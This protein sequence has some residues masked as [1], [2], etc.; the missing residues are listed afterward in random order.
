MQ[1]LV[2]GMHRAGTSAFTRLINQLGAYVGAE[3]EMTDTGIGQENPKGHWERK[4][5]REANEALM[6]S[7]GCDWDDVLNWSRIEPSA[8]SLERFRRHTNLIALR[9][10]ANRPWAIKD[11]RLCL[12][13]SHWLP[14]LELPVPFVVLRD[15]GEV[16]VSLRTRN[17]FPLELGFALWEAHYRAMLRGI[18]GRR[19]VLADHRDLLSDPVATAKR[20]LEEFIQAGVRKLSSP[21]DLELKMSIDP[22][23]YRSKRE[24]LAGDSSE[25]PAY[26]LYAAMASSKGSF[27]GLSGELSARSI[28]ALERHQ[29]QLEQLRKRFT[30]GATAPQA[31]TSSQVQKGAPPPATDVRS[32]HGPLALPVGVELELQRLSSLAT[33]LEIEL[34]TAGLHQAQIGNE[35]SDCR[36]QL[37]AAREKA[38]DSA[39]QAAAMASE[40]SAERDARKRMDEAWQE[41]RIEMARLSKAREEEL[42]AESSRLRVRLDELENEHRSLALSH[43]SRLD[44]LAH[45]RETLTISYRKSLSDAE[46]VAQVLRQERDELSRQRAS[47][48]DAI[49]RVRGYATTIGRTMRRAEVAARDIQASVRWRVGDRF[50]RLLELV[51]LRDRPILSWSVLQDA[52]ADCQ[53]ALSHLESVAHATRRGQDSDQ[54]QRTGLPT[55]GQLTPKA[56]EDPS[57]VRRS[58]AG[59]R[60][61]RPHGETDLE[62]GGSSLHRLQLVERIRSALLAYKRSLKIRALDSCLRPFEKLTGL[63]PDALNNALHLVSQLERSCR[64][65]EGAIATRHPPAAP[66]VQTNLDTQQ[67]TVGGGTASPEVGRLGSDGAEAAPERPRRRGVIYTAVAGAYDGLKQPEFIWEDCDYVVFTD[68]EIVDPGVWRVHRMDYVN[69]DPTRSARFVKTH[70]HLYFADYAFSLWIDANLLLR[71]NGETLRAA[72]GSAEMGAFVHPHRDCVYS[73]AEEVIRRGG[74]DDKSIVQQHVASLRA[75]DYPVRNGL[76]ETNVLFRRHNA[77]TVMRL[78]NEWWRLIEN[79]SKRDQL[80]FNV[81]CWLTDFEVQ[82]LAA[83]GISV[84]NH[85]D[86]VRFQHGAASSH[87]PSQP[88]DAVIARMEEARVLQPHAIS[89]RIDQLSTRTATDVIVCVHNARDDVHACLS[90][91][92]PTLAEQDRLIVVDDGSD[93][94][95]QRMLEAFASERP[96]MHVVRRNTAGGYTV[97]ANA[98]YR[99]SRN[100]FLVFLNSDTIVPPNWLDKLRELAFS[101]PEIGIVGPLSNAASWQSV[102]RTLDESGKLAVNSLP[103]GLSVAEADAWCLESTVGRVFVPLINGFCFGVKRSVFDAIG[104]FDEVSFPRGYGEENDFCFRAADA[105]FLLAVATNCFVFHAKSKSYSSAGRDELAQAGSR[106]FRAKYPKARIDN[107][108]ATTRDNPLL[109]EVRARFERRQAA[110]LAGSECD[111]ADIGRTISP[112]P[113]PEEAGGISAYDLT[114]DDMRLNSRIVNSPW[115]FADA[116]PGSVL[117]FVPCF[118]HALRG[119]IRTI[120]TAAEDWSKSWGTFHYFALYGNSV[121]VRKC[122]AQLRQ[123]FPNLRYK[124]IPIADSVAVKNLP[125][126]DLGICTLWN[127]AYHL[128]KYNRCRA[129]M[130]FAQ[131]YEPTFY[132]AGTTYG[133]IQETYG[134]GFNVI[135]NSA[136]VGDR[137]REHTQRVDSFDPGVDTD[138]FR[139][140]PLKLLADQPRRIVFYGRPRNPRNAFEL[141]MESLR[142]LK[143]RMGEKV[144]IISVGAEFDPA[145]YGC[146]GA[147]RNLGVLASMEE[148]ADLYAGARAGLVF[149]YSAHPSYQPLEYMASGCATVTNAN[150]SN[151]WLLRN[152]ENCLVTRAVPSEIAERLAQVVTDDKLYSRIRD[153]GLRTV[154]TLSWPR[155]LER[156][157]QIVRRPT[158]SDA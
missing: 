155:A 50:V 31:Q 94:A 121:N 147:V 8:R 32:G 14:L 132:R 131:D 39:E 104:E 83:R 21:A 56:L 84:R 63:R 51:L 35:L 24:P 153:G 71:G 87:V 93:D 3:G 52:I 4:D 120:F 13:I 26:E 115:P 102:P 72:L 43:Q 44:E 49:S 34:A 136:G 74:L 126:T 12:T 65:E 105:G 118:D 60:E 133:L 79:G 127:S 80:S 76:F 30:K 98:G 23:L 53:N 143:Q 2:V 16:A 27:A 158:R 47:D 135:A 149:M 19:H 18:A 36:K 152:G 64:G 81:A 116:P 68:Q 90:S 82:P 146:E 100:P 137:V 37:I 138:L 20:I 107:A 157:R 89:L 114:A 154:S 97:A 142:L 124:V 41:D 17:A 29:K 61:S 40:L 140:A 130:Y 109:A 7:V 25:H 75:L 58:G 59:V 67:R 54:H 69:A 122:N 150:Y 70:P 73:E 117:W 66:M 111:V 151:R 108:I 113:L 101:S 103:E 96:G 85:P 119:G 55:P 123:Y 134:F 10:D 145:E 77:A 9:L 110:W 95:T 5:V 22:R 11:P 57:V 42:E 144:D 91:V 156:I 106:A 139:P 112:L 33:K 62:A 46:R 125:E 148:V 15:P 128:V 99:A 6:A 38:V 88:S 28:D 141:G 48:L 1:I 45:E 86:I 78:M 92:F 129:K